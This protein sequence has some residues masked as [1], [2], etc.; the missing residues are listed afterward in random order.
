MSS[1]RFFFGGSLRSIVL[2]GT[3]SSKSRKT[4]WSTKLFNM[5]RDDGAADELNMLFPSMVVTR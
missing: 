1:S 4:V 3:N 2:A 5:L